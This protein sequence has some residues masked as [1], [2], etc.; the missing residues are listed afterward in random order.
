M[1]KGIT[2]SG[3]FGFYAGICFVGWVFVIFCYAEVH[4]MPLE[5]V[6]EVYDHGFGVK[7]AKIM[8]R[9]MR[10]ERTLEEVGKA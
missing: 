7:Y 3:A 1:M 8:Q 5:T 4:N 2:P 6:R 9:R 10:E